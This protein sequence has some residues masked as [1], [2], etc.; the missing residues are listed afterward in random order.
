MN[1][2]LNPWHLGFDTLVLVS[3]ISY[4]IYAKRKKQ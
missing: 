3:V 1:A 4:V 2:L